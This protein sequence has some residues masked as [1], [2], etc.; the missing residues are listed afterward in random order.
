MIAVVTMQKFKRVPKHIGVIPDGNRRWAVNNGL[1]KED[2]YSHGVEPGVELYNLMI[3]YGIKE[4]TFY[5]FTKDNNKRPKA[6]RMAYT[7]ACVDSVN[8]VAH[9]DANILVV[10]NTKSDL[11]PAELEE[12]ANKRVNFG[13]G[14]I[15]INFLINYDWKSDIEAGIKNNDLKEIMSKD[16]SRMDLI[17]RW[18][19]RRRLSGF[20]PIQS[21][22]ADFYIVDSYW[23][24]FK[25]QDFLGALKWYENCDVTLGG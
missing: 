18:G 11:F 4:A 7:K 10:G 25:A 12:Y 3:E 23:P 16:I 13:E 2:G 21:V 15:N 6:Q 1:D 24:D 22:Y 19:E 5:G 8:S 17:I 9:K 14:K 20:L